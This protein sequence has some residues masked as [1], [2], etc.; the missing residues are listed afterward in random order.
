MALRTDL[1]KLG[2]GNPLLGYGNPDLGCSD[3]HRAIAAG[4]ICPQSG[5]GCRLSVRCKVFG[6]GKITKSTVMKRSVFNEC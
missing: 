5:V 4:Q 1:S 2:Y 6:S 3:S